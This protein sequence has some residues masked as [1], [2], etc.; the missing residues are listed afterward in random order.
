MQLKN[1]SGALGI[2]GP[3]VEAELEAVRTLLVQRRFATALATHHALRSKLRTGKLAKHY[4]DDAT[5]LTRD[6]SKNKKRKKYNY[7]Y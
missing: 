4:D 1:L 7:I 5:N 6:V 2:S 3:G